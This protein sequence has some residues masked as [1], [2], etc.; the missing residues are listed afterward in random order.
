MAKMVFVSGIRSFSG[1]VP[2]L[3]SS[4]CAY[5]LDINSDN[6][7]KLVDKSSVTN[8][9]W[10]LAE[11]LSYYII[12]PVSHA[13][14]SILT[15]IDLWATEFNSGVSLDGALVSSF[16]PR[17]STRDANVMKLNSGVSPDGDCD[18]AVNPGVSPEGGTARENITN[19]INRTDA[20]IVK[21]LRHGASQF[22]PAH[23]V[24]FYKCWWNQELDIPKDSSI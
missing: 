11:V 24:S 5:I 9:R 7:S 1:H 21:V 18:N 10:D 8:P 23:K 15:D 13:F 14:Q 2:L 6:G 20:N 12:I 16:V 4:I 22:I 17:V 19:F 3:V